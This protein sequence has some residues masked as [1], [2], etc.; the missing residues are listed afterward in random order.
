MALR[1][2]LRAKLATALGHNLEGELIIAGCPN[3]QFPL[4]E[5]KY[6]FYVIYY[7]ETSQLYTVAKAAPDS[8]DSLRDMKLEGPVY[9]LE[10]SGLE[11]DNRM[12]DESSDDDEQ[13]SGVASGVAL[14]GLG[15]VATTGASAAPPLPLPLI[16]GIA[17]VP[18]PAQAAT[19]LNLWDAAAPPEPML[20]VAPPEQMLYPSNYSRV[21][22]LT[23]ED[24]QKPYYAPGDE[25]LEFDVPQPPSYLFP[26]P[27]GVD[28]HT[29]P[30][31]T[32]SA[33]VKCFK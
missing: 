12:S 29:L 26:V 13:A 30:F 3:R 21:P 32:N 4:V 24:D 23:F 22:G 14:V 16:Q 11:A 5:H 15:L 2:P 10:A 6:M 20:D 17:A 33:S 9:V 8:D 25:D 7:D 28:P 18:P 1:R 19:N 31:C 27:K